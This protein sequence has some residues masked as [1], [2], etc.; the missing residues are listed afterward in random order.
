MADPEELDT[1]EQFVVAKGL[2]HAGNHAALLGFDGTKRLFAEL[3]ADGDRPEVRAQEAYQELLFSIQPG[4]ALRILQVF[5]PDP[6]PRTEFLHYLEKWPNHA[7][8]ALDILHS[9]LL[10][11]IQETILPSLRRTF[12]EFV[13][14]GDE[15][16]AWWE[17]ISGV[18][19]TFGVL[20]KYLDA[21]EIQELA[22]RIMNPGFEQ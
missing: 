12:I 3:F 13:L 10:L 1:T 7:S 11:A 17:G 18:C 4:W 19:A 16:L 8:E 6:Q 14:P 2:T 22:Y 9:G 5:W 15:G 20:I 21:Q